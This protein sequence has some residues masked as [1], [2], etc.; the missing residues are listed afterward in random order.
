MGET[1][2][3]YQRGT[4]LTSIRVDGVGGGGVYKQAASRL[5]L[6]SLLLV[7]SPA[8]RGKCPVTPP[9]GVHAEIS[10]GPPAPFD[11]DYDRFAV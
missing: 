6:V 9:R 1:A 11:P 5:S 4:E 3:A 10:D 2:S 8:M 7:I